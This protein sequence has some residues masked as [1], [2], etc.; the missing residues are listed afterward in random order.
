MHRVHHSS[1]SLLRRHSCHGSLHNITPTNVGRVGWWPVIATRSSHS[2]V[3]R[4]TRS[5]KHVQILC[6]CVC[7]YVGIA[8]VSASCPTRARVFRECFS[9]VRTHR[10]TSLLGEPPLWHGRPSPCTKRRQ[11][12]PESSLKTKIFQPDRLPRPG[13]RLR[14]CARRNSTQIWGTSGRS[15]EA[16]TRN[17]SPPARSEPGPNPWQRIPFVRTTEG[18]IV[19][20]ALH[21]TETHT[22]THTCKRL[23]HTQARGTVA[24]K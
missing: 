9:P 21:K 3:A 20:H 2:F 17:T 5:P 19:W 14:G 23:S 16:T 4:H 18:S 10:S 15:P 1:C 24:A 6:A 11:R 22:H 8:Y 12:K 13:A 7:L